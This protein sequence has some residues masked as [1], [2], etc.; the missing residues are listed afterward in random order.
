MVQLQAIELPPA[1]K[2][3]SDFSFDAAVVQAL[4]RLEFK[5]PVTFLMGENGTGKS[6][7]LESLAAGVGTATVGR[8]K[9][10]NDPSLGPARELAAALHFSWKKRTHKG[11]FLRAEDFFGFVQRIAQLKTELRAD[12]QE[13]RNELEG[14]S[15]YGRKL[16]EGPLRAG[17]SQLEARYGEDLDANSHGESFLKLFK[18]RLI[19][20]GLY[21]LD[22]PEAI[23]ELHWNTHS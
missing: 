20:D 10:R 5:S 23:R 11:F 1:A 3:S 13:V 21:L 12:L 19:P 7:L 15:E 22:E 2:R 9:V 17:L 8:E 16:A 14:R 6:L 18:S 4:T